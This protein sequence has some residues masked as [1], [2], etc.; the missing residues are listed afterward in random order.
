MTEPQAEV[1]ATAS[2]SPVSP[3]PLHT[4]A[5]R[6]VPALQDTVDTLDAMVAAVDAAAGSGHEVVD[7]DSLDDAYTDVA[8][9]EAVP[10]PQLDSSDDYAK[11]FDSPVDPEEGGEQQ[12]PQ[13]VSSSSKSSHVPLPSDSMPSVAHDASAEPKQQ[14]PPPEPATNPDAES[15]DPSLDIQKLVADLTAQPAESGSEG[16]PSPPS[17]EPST[18]A[19]P[20]SSSLPPRPPQPQTGSP[21]YADAAALN[22]IPAA[23]STVA[24][25]AP[26]TSEQPASGATPPASA[27][28]AS[29]VLA[30]PA[31]GMDASPAA[32]FLNAQ[33]HASHTAPTLSR[34]GESG[35]DYQRQWEQFTADERQYMSDAK[36]DRF[37]DGSRIFIGNLSSDK[38]SKRDVFDVFHKYGKLAQISLKSAYGF[39]QYHTVDEGR[40]AMLNLQNIE[41]KGRRIHLEVSRVQEKAKKDRGRSPSDRAR[42]RRGDKHHQGRDDYRPH[43]NHSPRRGGGGGGGGD[44]HSRDDNFGRSRGYDSAR[45]G[46][47]RS[48][49]PDYGRK[50]RD[51]YRRRSPSP[52]GRSRHEADLDLPRRYGPDV[53]DVQFILQPEVN[54][55]FA[56]Y[57]ESV[58]KAKGLKTEVMYLHPRFPKDQVIQRQAAEG[59]YGVVD[60]DLISQEVGRIPVQVFDRSGGGNNVRFDKYVNL[61]PETAAEVIVRAKATAAAIYGQGYAAG[62]GNPYGGHHPQAPH[63]TGYPGAYP[64]PQQP[65]PSAADIANLIG[66]V[67]NATLQRIL[68]SISGAPQAPAITPG[69]GVGPPAPAAG[70]QVDIQGLLGSLGGLPPAQQHGP[71]PGQYGAAYGSQAPNGGPTNAAPSGAEAAAQVQNIMAQLARYRQ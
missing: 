37:P 42:G 21:S 32:A 55:D 16:E 26:P 58:F 8:A 20:S 51:A 17:A 49:S 27:E 50:D 30:S 13:H 34:D 48:R 69:Y 11:T 24:G 61:P 39:V 3:A 54:R 71:P 64:P 70:S 38:V 67:D 2:L 56:S 7:D 4:A 62:Y 14:L 25:T 41:I 31:T 5:P 19:L 22:P 65:Q 9:S 18:A 12:P 47:G 23:S 60:L 44:Y 1:Q 40:K 59:V 15:R 35:A 6:V 68:S 52:H 33:L 10:P 43:R 36:W 28:P 66:Q 57:I 46:R 63:G 53:P 45:G 29:S